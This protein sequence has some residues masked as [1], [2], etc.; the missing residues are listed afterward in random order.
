MRATVPEVRILSLPPGSNENPHLVC[1]IFVTFLS[2][3]LG[4]E[5]Q[6]SLSSTADLVGDEIKEATASLIE[7]T[8]EA[9]A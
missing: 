8:P 1:G 2:K 5:P 9:K 7:M 4:F 3:K 6:G